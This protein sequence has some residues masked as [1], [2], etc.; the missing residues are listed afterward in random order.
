M[1]IQ[2]EVVGSRGDIKLQHRIS[3]CSGY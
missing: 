3:F 1:I 2:Y